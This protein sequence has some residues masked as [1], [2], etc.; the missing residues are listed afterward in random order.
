MQ[1]KDRR[2]LKGLSFLRF[3]FHSLVETIKTSQLG[4]RFSPLVLSFACMYLA[5]KIVTLANAYNPIFL[6]S[7]VPILGNSRR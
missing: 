3:Y 5:P 7:T 6:K 1:L 4:G 2:G